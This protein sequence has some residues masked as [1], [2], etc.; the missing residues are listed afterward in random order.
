MNALLKIAEHVNKRIQ[1][2]ATLA[3]GIWDHKVNY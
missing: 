1:K 2:N 3:I